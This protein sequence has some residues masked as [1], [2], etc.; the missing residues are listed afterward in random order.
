[1]STYAM[2]PYLRT[3]RKYGGAAKGIAHAIP[4]NSEAFFS[5]LLRYNIERGVLRSTP[6]Y[7]AYSIEIFILIFT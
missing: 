3:N 7:S 4:K 2:L 5:P 1:M 6:S